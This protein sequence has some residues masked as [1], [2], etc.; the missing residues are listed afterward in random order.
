MAITDPTEISNLELWLDAEQGVFSDAGSTPAG[1]TD[2]VQQWND[3][4]G[5]NRHASQATSGNRPVFRT[6]ILNGKPVIRFTRSASEVLQGDFGAD[7][8]QP[9]TMI[10]VF[11]RNGTTTGSSTSDQQQFVSVDLDAGGGVE[12]NHSLY[13]A[14]FSGGVSGQKFS[15]FSGE[16]LNT[17][18]ADTNYHIMMGI[19]NGVSG[20]IRLDG[21]E[22]V[23]GDI[24]SLSAGGAYGIGGRSVTGDRN[25][26]GDIAEVIFYSKLLSESEYNDVECYLADKYGI[27][28]GHAC[29]VQH[30]QD[31]TATTNTTAT[32]GTIKTILQSL[33]GSTSVT[34]SVNTAKELLR[35]LQVTSNINASIAKQLVKDLTAT[36][37]T[38][39]SFMASRVFLQVIQS[40]TNVTA[41]LAISNA[42]LK[43]LTSEISTTASVATQK[44]I[45][46][47]L[48]ATTNVTATLGI[49]RQKTL[50]ATT[51]VAVSINTTLG[52]TL[53]VTASIISKLRAPFWKQKY[54]SHQ[55]GDEYNVKY[56]L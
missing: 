3:Q 26:D 24:G 15:A 46:R 45:A 17:G 39:A 36:A 27:S 28:I 4:S 11:K 44:T 49:V 50:Q 23:T 5:N 41:T 8:T 12:V 51:A 37:A 52:K 16:V 54:P 2:D 34:A 42:Y 10:V 30:D 19:Y 53:S 40:T 38:S 6:G 35:A 48:E 25:L 20:V 7:F 14:H 18:E 32:V 22:T 43:T 13:H 56:D 31:L 55:D 29:V 47:T 33:I 21:N 1:D 9:N